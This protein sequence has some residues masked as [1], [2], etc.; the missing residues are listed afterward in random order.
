MNT[1]EQTQFAFNTNDDLYGKIKD[2][3]VLHFA[4]YKIATEH[5]A[6]FRAGMAKYVDPIINKDCANEAFQ[7]CWDLINYLA[8]I[9]LQHSRA[10]RLLEDL[11]ASTNTQNDPRVLG[12]QALLG[13]KPLAVK[14][15]TGT[16]KVGDVRQGLS[17]PVKIETEEEAE[18]WD[19]YDRAVAAYKL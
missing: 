4:Q 16:N 7:E 11:A 10:L 14:K 12:I 17:G 9:K 3:D 18:G 2:E 5:E 15:K 13:S 8:A 6:K 19:Y 1:S